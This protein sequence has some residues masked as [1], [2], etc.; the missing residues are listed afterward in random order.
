MV[1]QVRNKRYKADDDEL[2]KSRIQL[3]LLK[4]KIRKHKGQK[5]RSLSEENLNFFVENWGKL[6][7][8]EIAKKIG[9]KPNSLVGLATDLNLS[10]V[11]VDDDEMILYHFWVA[12]TGTYCDSYSRF[13]AKEWGLPMRKERNWHIISLNKFFAW[14]KDHIKLINCWHYNKG[15]FPIEPDW[16]LTK[17]EA[18][19]R[20]DAYMY[21]R[22][23]SAEEDKLLLS[24]INEGKGYKDISRRLK[25]TGSAIKRRCYDLNFPKPKRYPPKLWTESEIKKLK[26]LWHKGYQPCIIAEELDKSDRQIINMLERYHYFGEPP[27]KYS[28][29]G[30][31]YET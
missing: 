7:K 24:L 5:Q 28:T 16:F 17:V 10:V 3:I 12:L 2:R 20:A 23:W 26:E 25:R 8:E 1:L 31:N 15:D 14:Y 18:D 30:G 19:K 22:V 27:Q 13:L 6:P 29:N 21:K 11:Y 9:R 4:D